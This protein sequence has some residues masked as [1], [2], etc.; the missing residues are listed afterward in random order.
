MRVL[1]TG[2]DGQV[3]QALQRAAWPVNVVV[4]MQRRT[5]LDI[6]DPKAIEA[7]VATLQPD[8]LINAAAYTAVDRAE[9]DAARAFAVNRDGAANL[10][11]VCAAQ[12][13]ALLHI[14]TDYVFDGSGNRPWREDDATNPLGVYGA[15][16]LAGE[17]AVR[18]RLDQ[19]VILRTAWVYAAQGQNFVRTM[20][21]LADERDEVRVVDDQIG[22]PTPADAIAAAIVRIAAAIADKQAHWGTFHFAGAGDISWY[23]FARAIFDGATWLERTPRITPIRTED[24]PTPARRPKNSR[25]DCTRIRTAYGIETTPWREQ[26]SRVLKDIR[27]T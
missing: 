23:G 13:V 6:T 9:N 27:P 24:Y 21:R 22:N 25:L 3:G 8:L 18:E 1:V 4:S 17:E 12:D 5:A 2:A 10:A 19:H 11:G 14:S 20:L 26:L 7:A 16:K 15:S